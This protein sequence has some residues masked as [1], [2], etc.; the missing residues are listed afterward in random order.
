MSA[1][2]K[3]TRVSAEEACENIQEMAALYI[4]A[5]RNIKKSKHRENAR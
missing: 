5:Q 1:T 2:S 3:A 4:W